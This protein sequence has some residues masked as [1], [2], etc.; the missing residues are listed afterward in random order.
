MQSGNNMEYLFVGGTGRCGT[1]IVL[2]YL[3][4]NSKI[5]STMPAE[6]KILTTKD[7]L[8]DLYDTKNLDS[9][10]F[11]INQSVINKDNGQN[12][13]INSLNYNDVVEMLNKLNKNFMINNKESLKDFYFNCFYKQNIIKNN[14]KY[15]ADSTPETIMNSD[16]IINVIPDSKFIHMIR[17]GRDSG[18]SEY[19]LM[20]NDKFFNNIKNKF[21]GLDFWHRRIIKSFKSLESLND[22]NYIN[23]RVEDFVVN[24]SKNQKEKIVNF[25]KIDDDLKMQNFYSKNIKESSMSVGQWKKNKDWKEYDRKYNLILEDLKQQGIIIEKYY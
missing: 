17:D 4:N 2:E 8:L 12:Y 9:F 5:Y 15:F 3:G 11:Y 10:N 14:I 20:K 18:Y 19:R 24:D 22:N 16:R 21:D 23:I 13:F 7:G 1:T 6:I 25:L